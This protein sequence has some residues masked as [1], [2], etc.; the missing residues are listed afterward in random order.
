MLWLLYFSRLEKEKWF[1]AIVDM[2]EMFEKK[3]EKLP[4][5]LF[6]FGSGSGEKRIQELADKYKTIHFFWR[7]SLAT[8]KR[9]V[10]NCSYCLMPSECLESFGLSA[11]IAMKRW[12]PV[13]GYAKWGLQDFISNELDL[14]HQPWSTT[15][16]KLH[17]L[18][19]SLLNKKVSDIQNSTF[20]IQNYIKESRIVRFHSHAGKGVKKIIMVSDFINRIGGIETYIND[21]KELLEQHGYEVELCGWTV[22]WWPIWKLI[23]YLGFVTWL[24]NFREV[25]KLRRK[26]KKI[27]PDLIRYHSV[28]RYLGRA[29]LRASRKSTAKKRMMFHDLGYFYP[30]PSKLTSEHQIKSPFTLKNFL[31]SYKTI[32]LIKKLAIIGK[33]FSLRLIKRQMKKRIDTYLVPS[34][35][36]IDIT[37]KSYNISNDKIIVFPHFIQD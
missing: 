2:I 15:A 9:Y 25:I 18:V 7:K 12:L 22:S 33:Y 13:I 5:E 20:N 19:K 17:N 4:F 31:S 23:K 8:I 27:N 14:T 3:W 1:D 11:L 36:M 34:P 32:C 21:A 16:Q 29:S 30:F 28:T 35:F 37:H 24:G 26:I 10:E 6:V